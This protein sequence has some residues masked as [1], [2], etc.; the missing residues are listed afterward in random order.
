MQFDIIQVTEEELKKMSKAK[1]RLLRT[2]QQKKDELY[3]NAEKQMQEFRIKVLSAGMKNSS[4]LADKQ[5]ETDAELE[6]K[7]GILADNLVYAMSVCDTPAGS[8][9]AE[10][11]VDYSLSYNERYII[12][13]DYYLKITD[14]KER[15]SKYSND[16]VAKKYLGTYYSTLYNILATYEK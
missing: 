13:R 5:A 8:E 3:R 16:E 10:Y 6:Y 1:V 14:V 15:M 7:C 12:V 11:L 2:A 9:T 4:L